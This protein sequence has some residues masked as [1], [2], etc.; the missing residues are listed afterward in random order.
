[1]LC[2]SSRPCQYAYI[3]SSQR[4][5]IPRTSAYTISEKAIR[6]RHPDYN[7]DPAQKLISSSTSRHLSTRNISSKSMHASL[8]RVS[9]LTCDFDIPNLSV[10]LS[11]MF[12]YQM[13]TAIVFS[14][15]TMRCPIILVYQHQA[16]SRNFDGVTPC[17]GAK[18]RW[19]IKISRFSTNKSLSQTIQHIAI[20]TMEGE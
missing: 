8:S 14:P 11:V 9:I 2:C 15:F 4:N 17:G 6:L 19:G 20:V 12:Q 5:K 18:Y 3:G 7:P 1:M 13:K 10:H 16:S